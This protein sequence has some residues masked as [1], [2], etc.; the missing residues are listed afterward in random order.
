MSKVATTLQK[1]K[2]V[3]EDIKLTPL[4]I[5]YDMLY[6]KIKDMNYLMK[7]RTMDPTRT[8]DK[9]KYYSLQQDH[10]HIVENCHNFKYQL[11]MEARN[12]NLDEFI[13][14]RLAQPMQSMWSTDTSM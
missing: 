13:K 5:S 10:D 1:D 14:G 3:Q 11:E 7:P 9:T 4:T 8:V 12:R 2:Q 6:E